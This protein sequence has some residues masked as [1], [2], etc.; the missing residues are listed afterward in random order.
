MLVGKL[1]SYKKQ[2]PSSNATIQSILHTSNEPL[3]LTTLGSLTFC[4]TS[5]ICDELL[6]WKSGAQ[7]SEVPEL[8]PVDLGIRNEHGHGGGLAG[9][10]GS[11]GLVL[12]LLLRPHPLH[13]CIKLL[14]WTPRA[15]PDTLVPCCSQLSEATLFMA[16][17]QRASHAKQSTPKHCEA[18]TVCF[19]LTVHVSGL[20]QG[21]CQI[22]EGM[23]KGGQRNCCILKLRA[24]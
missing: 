5:K 15:A 9:L 2:P 13:H 1:S 7:G 19:M 21:D 3:S 11:V 20:G 22:I 12:S 6:T 17:G 16:Q 8:G 4:T 23:G 14:V 10:E 18:V 24:K